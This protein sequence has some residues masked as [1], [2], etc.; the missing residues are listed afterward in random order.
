MGSEPAPPRPAS[1]RVGLLGASGIGRVHAR[2]FRASGADIVAV[3]GSTPESAAAAAAELG[4]GVEPFSELARLLERPLDA[5]SICTP[6]RLH[7]EQLL[8][9]F[10]S[11]LPAFCEK[12]LFWTEGQDLTEVERKLEVLLAHPRRELFVNTSNAAFVDA[13]R[14]RLPASDQV[15]SFRFSFHTQ[16]P[17]RG[18][19]IAVD[20]LPH[21]LSLLLRLLGQREPASV[22]QR[23]GETRHGLEFD[24]GGC[25]VELDLREDGGGARHLG[26]AVNGDEYRRLQAG[27]GASY[28]VELERVATGERIRLEDPFA[29]Y[30]RDFVRYCRGRPA[31]REDRAHEAAANLRLMAR[32][33]LPPSG[34]AG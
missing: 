12:P 29:I 18:R 6:A 2:I 7:H 20:L 33:L 4:P 5:V 13:V 23:T 14:D 19:D 11:G 22:T 32:I 27:S 1:L 26:F 28:R 10:D 31:S 16:G 17:W 21:A 25:R 34:D 24:Y 8:A 30:I 15:R 9:A 3:L